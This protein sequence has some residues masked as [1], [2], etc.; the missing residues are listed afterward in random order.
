M[1]RLSQKL[2][3]KNPAKKF[4]AGGVSLEHLFEYPRKLQPK[5]T[6]PHS[7]GSVPKLTLDTLFVLCLILEV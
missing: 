4:F 1:G 2:S 6:K 5:P 3:Q 7:A